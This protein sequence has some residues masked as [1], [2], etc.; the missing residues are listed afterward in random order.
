MLP[1][2]TEEEEWKV[3][4]EVKRRSQEQQ[5]RWTELQTRRK[6]IIQR[7]KI[8]N[9]TDEQRE[10]ISLKKAEARKKATPEAKVAD[11]L[12]RKAKCEEARR[13]EQLAMG[14]GQLT[15]Y[16]SNNL[17]PC[18]SSVNQMCY[19]LGGLHST[20]TYLVYFVYSKFYDISNGKK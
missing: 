12:R 6:V 1:E 5:V 13:R 2:A 18:S 11:V 20:S 16:H 3:L 7:E 9:R 19:H 15:G 8:N 14:N 10:Q 4:K 17:M